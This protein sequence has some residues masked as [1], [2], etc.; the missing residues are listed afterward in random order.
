MNAWMKRIIVS[1][2]VLVLAAGA[3]R[4]AWELLS[5]AVPVLIALLVA[6]VIF[7]HVLRGPKGW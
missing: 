1:L 2:A 7:R 4:L 6:F 3:T 5:P